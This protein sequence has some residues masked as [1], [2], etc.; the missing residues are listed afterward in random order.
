MLGAAATVCAQPR[1]APLDCKDYTKYLRLLIDCNISWKK[2]FDCITLKISKIGSYNCKTKAPRY[3]QTRL[4][5][6]LLN[7]DA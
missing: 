5:G 4:Y 7:M 2:H 6:H 1:N 3:H